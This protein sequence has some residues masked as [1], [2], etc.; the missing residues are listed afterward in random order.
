MLNF[1]GTL[2]ECRLR[3]ELL[4]S[5][6][7]LPVPMLCATNEEGK[8]YIADINDP[9]CVCELY[10]SQNLIPVGVFTATALQTWAAHPNQDALEKRLLDAIL[11]RDTE[12]ILF[13][14]VDFPSTVPESTTNTGETHELSRQS[15]RVRQDDG[16]STPPS[17]PPQSDDQTESQG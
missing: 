14:L 9:S 6:G 3:A 11:E 8:Y 17:E 4:F 1:T 13:N 7:P 5:T 16:D 15:Q 2:H 12:P 10:F